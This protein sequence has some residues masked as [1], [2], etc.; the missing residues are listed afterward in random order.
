MPAGPAPLAWTFPVRIFKDKPVTAWG[1]R[2]RVYGGAHF[3]AEVRESKKLRAPTGNRTH[4]FAQAP[5]ISACGSNAD[6][7]PRINQLPN[8]I[9]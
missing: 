1:G 2:G 5:W 3:M 8:E 9:I 4:E 7:F 6:V